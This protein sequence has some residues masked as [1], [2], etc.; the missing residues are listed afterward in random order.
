[1]LVVALLTLASLVF[2]G[3]PAE[4]APTPQSSEK[5]WNGNP[6]SAP[7]TPPDR[8][9]R[10]GVGTVP[11]Q[12]VAA[13]SFDRAVPTTRLVRVSVVDQHASPIRNATVTLAYGPSA[14]TRG[15]TDDA[16]ML[17]IRREDPRSVQVEAPG[18]ATCKVPVGPGQVDARI[19]L[20][21]VEAVTLVVRVRDSDNQAVPHQEVDV[22]VSDHLEQ[23][24]T[25]AP[26]HRGR[27]NERGEIE[28]SSLAEA[29]Y[30]VRCRGWWR[31]DDADWQ[32]V[33]TVRGTVVQATVVMPARPVDTY[34]EIEVVDAEARLRWKNGVAANYVVQV[35]DRTRV[36]V[37]PKHGKATVVGQPGAILWIRLARIEDNALRDLVPIGNWV[38]GV[39]GQSRPIVL[40]IE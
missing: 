38:E 30:V 33:R 39:I 3:T 27:T 2:R 36:V 13:E 17:E 12:S 35:Q 23:P 7:A 32:T 16:G 21:M 6:S 20:A 1:L 40:A 10:Q 11:G 9:E 4:S 37:I 28:F 14:Q 24:R 26:Q 22:Q 29:Q 5:P 18:F 19:D 8:P 25:I 34:F 15:T 31:W